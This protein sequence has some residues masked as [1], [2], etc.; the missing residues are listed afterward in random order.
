MVKDDLKRMVVDALSALGGTGSVTEV[1]RK[2][3]DTNE[4]ELRA[5]G[6]VFYTWQYDMRWAAQKLADEG[7]LL[8]KEE[9][10]RWR[11]NK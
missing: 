10:G 5:G 2:I 3:W 9:K 8:K 6:D 1:A 11:L 4:D 7:I